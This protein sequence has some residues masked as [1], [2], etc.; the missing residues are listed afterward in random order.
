[1]RMASL[2]MC[3]HGLVTDG[4]PARSDVSK[5]R[6]QANQAAVGAA[7]P[8]MCLWAALRCISPL[9]RGGGL[10]SKTLQ[11][12]QQH[13]DQDQ[14]QQRLHGMPA[15]VDAAGAGAGN[16]SNCSR[17]WQQQQVAAKAVAHCSA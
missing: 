10:G 3:K 1:M 16:N 8:S 14:Q 13:L 12:T 2:H 6:L 5:H 17:A 4:L 9:N 11:H 15:H 7:S